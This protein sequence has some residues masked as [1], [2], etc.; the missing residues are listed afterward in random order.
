MANGTHAYFSVPG[1]VVTVELW[2]HR[3]TNVS[4]HKHEVKREGDEVWLES[5]KLWS[6]YPDE[7][8]NL[9]SAYEAAVKAVV[10]KARDYHC[11][12]AYYV[13]SSR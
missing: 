9:F 4:I 6:G 7:L 12:T 13:D 10:R 8:P 11:R 5:T 3:E 2:R 1:S